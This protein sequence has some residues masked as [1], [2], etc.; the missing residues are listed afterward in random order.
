MWN[1]PLDISIDWAQ[2]QFAQQLSLSIERNFRN[3]TGNLFSS[4][5]YHPVND[6]LAI[7][8][9]APYAIIHEYGGMVPERH[10]VAK[11]ALKF[12]IGSKEIFAKRARA[13]RLDAREYVKEATEKWQEKIGVG[14][15]G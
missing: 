6:G 12:E 7:Y 3:T 13:F 15:D 1:K 9:T 2:G 8:S 5:T 11:K 10:P 4:F 14:W